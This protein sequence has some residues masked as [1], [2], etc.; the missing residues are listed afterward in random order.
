MLILGRLGSPSSKSIDAKLTFSSSTSSEFSVS[1][2]SS[3]SSNFQNHYL[4]HL[5]NFQNLHHRHYHQNLYL[6][7]HS[8]FFHYL[9]I[10]FQEQD[11]ISSSSLSFDNFLI[12]V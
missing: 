10:N 9:V 3:S 11:Q 4:L 6:D 8:Y 7:Y 2:S 1:L 5:Q 12:H